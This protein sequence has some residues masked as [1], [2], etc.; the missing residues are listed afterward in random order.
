MHWKLKAECIKN[1]SLAKWASCWRINIIQIFHIMMALCHLYEEEA[2]GISK[3]SREGGCLAGWQGKS[4]L[5]HLAKTASSS[6][7][8]ILTPDL[9]WLTGTDG[10]SIVRAPV[11]MVMWT[12]FHPQTARLTRLCMQPLHSPC[13]DDSSHAGVQGLCHTVKIYLENWPCIFF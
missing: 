4:V 10:R 13:L 12:K 2:E 11:C 3:P 9:L 8:R 1:I 5:F 6:P 7:E